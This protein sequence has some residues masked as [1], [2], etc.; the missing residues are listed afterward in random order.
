MTKANLIEM[1]NDVCREL[2]EER[3]ERERLK[4]ENYE[5]KRVLGDK[6]R[7]LDSLVYRLRLEE[8]VGRGAAQ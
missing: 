8:S 5:L 3:T 4:M 1:L 2:K 6:E 7:S